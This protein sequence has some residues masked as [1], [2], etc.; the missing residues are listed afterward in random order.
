MTPDVGRLGLLSDALRLAVKQMRLGED[1]ELIC[2]DRLVIHTKRKRQL[3]A[4]DGEKF[5]MD[6]PLEFTMVR[7]AFRIFTPPPGDEAAA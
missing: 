1:F 4:C 7:D 5:L 6:G 2:A 3:V